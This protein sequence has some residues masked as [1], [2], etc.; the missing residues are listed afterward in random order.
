MTHP[1][2]R[3]PIVSAAFVAVA[4]T[5][6]ACTQGLTSSGLS[7]TAGASASAS[8]STAP[9]ATSS[10]APADPTPAASARAS[11]ASACG[12][13]PQT[14]MLPSD[15][16]VNLTGTAG[17]AADTLTFAFG[18]PSLPGPSTPPQARLEAARPPYTQAGSGA[19]IPLV[20]RHVVA[21]RFTGMSLQNDAGEETYTGPR[22]IE[23]SFKGLRDAVVYDGSEGVI[24]WYVGY[25]GPG[26]VTLA[27]AGASITLTIAHS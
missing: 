6:V 21:I 19:T 7:A 26:C 10:A 23:E 27:R 14:T 25:D 3:H 2:R 1:T 11:T 13:V 8:V 12:V 18:N 4:L 24:A 15:R 17:A 22:T 16:L 9:S 20:G 5:V